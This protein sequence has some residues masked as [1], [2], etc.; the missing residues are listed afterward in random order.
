MSGASRRRALDDQEFLSLQRADLGFDERPLLSLRVFATG[1]A[2]DP[3]PARAA[4]FAGALDAVK[5]L[6]GVTAAAATSAVPGDDGGAL[7]RVTKDG[8]AGQF[9]GAH[10]V[11]VTPGLFDT[12]V[13]RMEQGRTFTANEFAAP[14]SD[15]VMINES[16][17]KR[18]WPGQS[19]L[20]RRV[21]IATADPRTDG[22]SWRRVVG[23]APDLVYEELGE[24]TELIAVFVAD[25]GAQ[26]T[27]LVK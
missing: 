25:E 7:I 21:R 2:F 5:A 9:V 16:L 13:V 12:L 4:L 15:A 10:A 3:I 22:V 26:L 27:T 20:D 24:Q 6:P 14:E 23:V 17:A 1:D 19:A 8:A 11:T 18:L